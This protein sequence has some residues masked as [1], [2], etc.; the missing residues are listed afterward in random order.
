MIQQQLLGFMQH[1]FTAIGVAPQ[2]STPQIGQPATTTPVTLV[3][4]PNALPSQ[5]QPAPQFASPTEQVSQ[6]FAS[7]GIAQGP[8]FTPIVIGFTP[9]QSYSMLV[10]DTPVSRSL[11]A[12][13]SE[14]T[15]QSTPLELRVPAPTIVAPVIRTTETLPSSVA[16]FEPPQTV[17]PTLEASATVTVA[18][19]AP[20]P[21]EL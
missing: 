15:E 5:R 12:T 14:L 16:S 4:Q 1:V 8:Y 3:V 19:V 7:P 20:L 17:T 6:W 10:M 13:F 9:S 11:G 21:I 2:Q 18:D